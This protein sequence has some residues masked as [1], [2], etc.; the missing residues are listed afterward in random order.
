MH[1]LRPSAG[2]LTLVRGVGSEAAKTRRRMPRMSQM[3]Y[4]EERQAVMGALDEDAKASGLPWRI[5][6]AWY[7]LFV[8]CVLFGLVNADFGFAFAVAN[9]VLERYPVIHDD[10]EPWETAFWEVQEKIAAVREK[11]FLEGL[12]EQASI[13]SEANPVRVTVADQS[14]ALLRRSPRAWCCLLANTIGRPLTRW[15]TRCRLRLRRVSR[16]LVRAKIANA[17]GSVLCSSREALTR[18]GL[19]CLVWLLQ[20]RAAT[21]GHWSEH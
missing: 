21:R 5:V 3:P 18:A 1:R 19:G 10:P 8:C 16:K 20:T 17:A 13:F 6:G 11:A 9:S 7:V 12:G 4:V 2:P 15:S 14:S